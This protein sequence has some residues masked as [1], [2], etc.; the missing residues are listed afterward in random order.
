MQNILKKNNIHIY[1]RMNHIKYILTT[2]ALTFSSLSAQ[3][4]NVT[5]DRTGEDT[6]IELPVGM[7]IAEDSLLNEW[8]V[9]AYLYDDTQEAQSGENPVFEPEVYKER[10][11]RLPC[12]MEMPYNNIVQKF[13]DQYTGRLR[14]NVSLMLAAGNFYMPIFEEALD[15]YGLPLELKYLPVIES[16]LDPNAVSKAGATGLWQFMLATGQRYGLKVNSLIDERRD[17][18]KATQAAAKYLKDLYSIYNDW[19]LV[20]AA[21]NCGPAKVNQAIHRAEGSRDYWEIYPYLPKETRGYLP[22]FIAANYV[23]NYYCEHNIRPMKTRMPIGTD[24]IQVARDLHFRQIADLCQ[25]DI[26]IVRALNPQYRTD[27][28]PGYWQMST[29]RLPNEKLNTLID[30]KDSIYNY[31]ADELFRRRS[32]VL[33]REIKEPA[34]PKASSKRAKAHRSKASRKGKATK[35]KAKKTSSKRR[36]SR[37][38]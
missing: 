27:V 29:L 35:R 24:T 11:R 26:E 34:R 33:V 32:E 18:I 3:V 4:V 21:Y 19:T 25:I 28:V 16:G 12:V 9:K 2:L 17:P 7:T 10:L 36:K 13:I 37:R 38:R 31:R 20:I 1:H 30:Y 6:E 22:A 15:L 14:H 5:D 8:H 23:M